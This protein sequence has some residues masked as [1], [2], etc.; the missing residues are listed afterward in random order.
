MPERGADQ[1]GTRGETS[2][3]SEASVRPGARDAIAQAAVELAA[4]PPFSELTPVERAKLAA[5]L[6]EVAYEPGDVIFAE[7]EPAD[8][9][10]ILRQGLV[11]RLAGGVRL[12]L[13]QP[14]AVFGDLALLRKERRAT[15]LVALAPCTV[16][17]LPA[18]R[19]TRLVLRTPGIGARFAATVSDRLVSAQRDVAGLAREVEDLAERLYASLPPAD[20]ALLERAAVMPIL[21]PRVAPAFLGCQETADWPASLPLADVL[22]RRAEEPGAD[23]ERGS[24]PGYPPA[25]RRF[26]L[27]RM[28]E[29][30]GAERLAEARREVARLAAK[31][32]AVD[33]RVLTLAEGG[34]TAEAGLVSPAQPAQVH[35]EGAVARRRWRPGRTAVGLLLG[36]AVFVGGWLAPAPAGLQPLA[37]HALVTLLAAVPVLALDALPEGIVALG[38]AAAWVVGGIATPAVAM[39]GFASA[40]WV[41]VVS[42][43]LIGAA[44]ASSG[45]L[46]R[47]ALWSV[48]VSRGGFAGQTVALALAGVLLGP[49][50]PNATGRVML[51]A[52][53]VSD[54]IE[55]LGYAPMSRGAAGLAM[56]SLL[57]FGQMVSPFL[58]SSTT[59]VLVYALLPEASRAGLSWGGWAVRAAPTNVLLFLGLMAAVIWLYRPR[60]T[61]EA[62]SASGARNAQGVA[63]QRALLGPLGRAEWVSLAVMAG[64]LVGFVSQPLHGVEPAWIGVGALVVLAASGVL[65]VEGLRSVN[66]SFVLFFGI[67]PSMAAVLERV[68]LDQWLAGLVTGV[69]GDL[70]STPVL[71]VAAL[72]LISF[73]VSFVMRWQAAAPLL[74]IALMPVAARA[75]MDPWIVAMVPLVACNGFF[76][77]YQSTTYLALYHGTGGRLF[78]HA[79]ARPA[80]V[81]YGVVTLL[82]LCASVPIW[83]AMGLL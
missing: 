6:E 37:W 81:A 50:N 49:A 41:L 77:P 19:F 26:L 14:P 40:G 17:R 28:E 5:A 63:L 71:F 34:L 73:A 25:F 65:T 51:V 72:T 53:A 15:T 82:A 55:A 56:A 59:A 68:G 21:D 44:I 83:H 57:G 18:D 22:L 7:N 13:V 32:G 23:G 61:A 10:Y 78:S 30:V 27:R 36:G 20:R 62:T 2:R 3:P 74:T 70:V 52:P 16:W 9:L 33:L 67:L 60:D 45:L 12:D 39:S 8:A 24:P 38:L 69:L 75:G 42:V 35:G 80:A 79:Q 64:I 58:T 29:R 1:G 46:Y 43:L 54:L 76:L 48:T 47:L 66:W 31:A 4:V 11:E